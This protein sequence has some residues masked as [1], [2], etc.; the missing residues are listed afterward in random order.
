MTVDFWIGVLFAVY[1]YSLFWLGLVVWLVHYPVPA[2]RVVALPRAR[3]LSAEQRS[4]QRYRER[5][6]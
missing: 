5:R 2:L 1:F 6:Y 3:V 4:W